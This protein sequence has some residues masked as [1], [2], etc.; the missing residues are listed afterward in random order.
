MSEKIRILQLGTADWRKKYRLPENIDYTYQSSFTEEP[1]KRY[2]LVFLDRGLQEEELEPLG[3]ATNPHALYVTERAARDCRTERFCE[4]KKGKRIAESQIQSFLLQ[5]VRNYFPG[6]YGEKFCH[7][8]LVIA[9]GFTGKICWNGN[10]SVSLQG[11]FGRELRQAVFWRG[12]FPVD[13]GQAIELW[14]EYQKDSSVTI[15]LSVTQFVRGS[16]SDVQ[17]R[18]FFSEEDMKEPVLLDNQMDYGLVFVSLLA[19]GS[20]NLEII[21]LHDR[22]SR[23]GH[24]WFLPGGERYVTSKREEVFSYFDP[25]DRKPPLNVFFSG[26]KTRQGFEGYHLMQKMG[27]PFLLIS[28]SRLEGGC[29]YM[30]HREYEDM[31]R[32]IICKYMEELDFTGSQVIMAGLSMGTTGA[33]YYGCDI[34]PHAL[35]LGKPLASIGEVAANETLY[36]PGGFP[37]SLDVLNYLGKASDDRAVS[38]LDA[39]FW[40]RFDASDWSGSKF[41]V[42]YMIEDDYERTAY[43]KIL[44][45]LWSKGVRVYGKGIHGRHNDD[46]E[47]VVTWFLN[48]FRKVLR[49][50]FG[51]GTEH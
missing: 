9:R 49:E 18:W 40:K 5:E 19:M 22:Y 25:G 48:Q 23:R 15:A 2:D 21:A 27:C 8:D 3:H 36:R 44:S 39:R 4:E 24:G 32:R 20:G 43:E 35:I 33:M 6:Q 16:V 34:Q 10:C 13:R 38:R 45:H 28:E 14:L 30:G 7:Q 1:K 51:R 29:F 42:S 31:I 41:V 46:T 26:Y 37:T 17:Q 50:D 47:A 12:N 11:D